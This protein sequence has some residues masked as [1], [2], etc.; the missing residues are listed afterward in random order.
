MKFSIK[1]VARLKALAR[2]NVLAR[3]SNEVVNA[4][5]SQNTSIYKWLH[6][7]NGLSIHVSIKSKYL[8]FDQEKQR[9]LAFVYQVLKTLW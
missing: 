7:S 9:S 2:F 1:M 3:N 8:Q 4:Q 6:F 5:S